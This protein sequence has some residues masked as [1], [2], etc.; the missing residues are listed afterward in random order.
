M[1]DDR[2]AK[3]CRI[4]GKTLIIGAVIFLVCS[5]VFIGI[6]HSHMPPYYNAEDDSRPSICDL[7][8]MGV[9][10]VGCVFLWMASFIGRPPPTV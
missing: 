8:C 7:W 10:G 4:I 9:V 5:S 3:W 6:Q 2:V 1:D